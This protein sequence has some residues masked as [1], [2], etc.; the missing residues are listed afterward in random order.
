MLNSYYFPVSITFSKA[1]SMN[2]F[3]MC[4]FQCLK[5]VIILTYTFK[6]VL[7]L[8]SHQNT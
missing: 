7:S 3:I 2:L 4:Y 6:N 5:N 1:L 8:V